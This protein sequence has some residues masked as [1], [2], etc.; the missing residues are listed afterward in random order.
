[1]LDDTTIRQ[2][3]AATLAGKL[4]AMR[5]LDAFIVDCLND[6]TWQRRQDA[7]SLAELRVA[8]RRSIATLKRNPAGKHRG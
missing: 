7:R 4:E 5:A 3:L 8:M 6:P 1:M 2:E